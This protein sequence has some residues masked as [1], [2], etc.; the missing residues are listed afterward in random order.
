V[1]SWLGVDVF[2]ASKYDQTVEKIIAWSEQ[3]HNIE[4]VIIIG[5]QVRK[6]KQA[7]EWSDL[8]LMVLA[9]DP[10]V[11]LNENSWLDQWGTPVCVFIYEIV[12]PFVKWNWLVKRVLFDDN[13]DVDFSILPYDQLD[14]VLAINKDIISKGYQVI[15]DSKKHF[16]DQKIQ[17]LIN[18]T[19]FKEIP[20]PSQTELCNDINDILFHIIW[21]IKKI[22]RKEL[23]VAVTTINSHINE[24]LL[25]LIE[26][27]NQSVTS[28]SNSVTYEGRFLEERTDKE[29]MNQLKHC[30]SKYDET[31]AVNTLNWIFDFTY[32]ISKQI[33]TE[34]GYDLNALQFDSKRKI[35]TEMTASP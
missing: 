26:T 11:L 22:K 8:D 7:D 3:D 31:D 30:F 12:L 14:D 28:K 10:Q 4:S 13:R 16:V 20:M 33:F 1:I 25:K 27:L 18:N 19:K 5:S 29:I 9:N 32:S 24:L 2:A 15:Y 34:N 17:I 35:F 21:I 6:E 23:F